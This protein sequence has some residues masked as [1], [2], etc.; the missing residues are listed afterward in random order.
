[1]HSGSDLTDHLSAVVVKKTPFFFKKFF[2]LFFK[3]L[4]SL[5]PKD[6]L[7]TYKC[8]MDPIYS[9]YNDHYMIGYST[10]SMVTPTLQAIFVESPQ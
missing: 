3:F 10:G 1:M 6:H 5:G 2:N 9:I 8:Y 4:N 7:Y